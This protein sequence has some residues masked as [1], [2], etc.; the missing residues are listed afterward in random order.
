MKMVAFVNTGYH[1]VLVQTATRPCLFCGLE[2]GSRSRLTSKR[3]QEMRAACVTRSLGS[4][5]CNFIRTFG[6]LDW[7]FKILEKCLLKRGH[8]RMGA[9]VNDPNTEL[10]DVE[11]EFSPSRSVKSSKEFDGRE[12]SDWVSGNSKNGVGTS[13]FDELRGEAN[14]NIE[15]KDS[16]AWLGKT[17][18]LKEQHARLDFSD[19][20]SQRIVDDGDASLQHVSSSEPIYHDDESRERDAVTQM[21]RSDFATPLSFRPSRRQ[22]QYNTAGDVSLG[23]VTERIGDS[24]ASNLKS[25]INNDMHTNSLEDVRKNV[26]V[27]VNVQDYSRDIIGSSNTEKA[28]SS[29]LT[30]DILSTGF[31]GSEENM[32]VI[33]DGKRGTWIGNAF[34][35]EG[36]KNDFWSEEKID[37]GVES[38]G[39]DASVSEQVVDKIEAAQSLKTTE[40][41][42]RQT[43]N[44]SGSSQRMFKR[45]RLMAKQ[46]VSQSSALILGFVSQLWVNPRFWE[47]M[48][49]EMRPSLLS[50]QSGQVLISDVCQVGDVILVRDDSALESELDALDC[51]TLVGYDLVTEDGYRLGKVRDYIINFIDGTVISL[52]FDSIGVSL[53]PSNMLSCLSPHSNQC[54]VQHDLQGHLHEQM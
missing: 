35:D 50:G 17:S 13:F 27:S 29:R 44:F 21:E 22:R 30:E 45:S 52:E 18:N 33:G 3:F 54:T 43:S 40:Y 31:V 46:V 28:A 36:S 42:R 12:E 5:E 49:L 25:Q 20:N 2:I 16:E 34:D 24:R 53:I 10:G 26:K 8:A 48:A 6:M 23:S 32:A 14:G 1:S 51:E 11:M 41:G 39:L 37:S 38:S 9:A 15:F 19:L 4:V 7:N 47:V